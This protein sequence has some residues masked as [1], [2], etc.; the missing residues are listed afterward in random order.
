M[1]SRRSWSASSI[2]R[3]SWSS[4]EVLE[5]YGH[6]PGGLLAN[7]LAFTALFA[8]VPIALVT[9]GVAGLLVKDPGPAAARYGTAD[10]VPPLQE[11]IEQALVSMAQGAAVT[12]IIGVAGLI[13][14]VSQFY[15]TLD[16]A[17]SR[18]F[19]DRPERDVLRGRL[20]GSCGSRGWSASSSR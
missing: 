6:A 10:V 9:L 4:A 7:G 20:A 14:T 19:A 3:R 8:V 1:R 5:V 18:I 15:V 11:L 2:D 17:F 16:V 13:W 12:S